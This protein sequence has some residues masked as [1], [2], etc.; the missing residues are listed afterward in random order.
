MNSHVSETR[1]SLS[2]TRRRP[3]PHVVVEPCRWILQ[4]LGL[5]RLGRPSAGRSDHDVADVT[6]VA[7]PDQLRRVAVE[8]ARSLLRAPLEDDAVFLDRLAQREAFR[9]CHAQRLFA[10]YVLPAAGR[11]DADERM[12]SFAWRD[13]DR[14]DVLPGQ[15]LAEIGEARQALSPY[16]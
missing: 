7:V 6:D 9:E 2:G 4:R 15:Q 5:L 10:I 13:D 16:C 8:V 11:L 12:P 3:E 14:V 1:T